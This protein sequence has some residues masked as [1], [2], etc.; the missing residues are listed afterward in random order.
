M[1]KRALDFFLFS[2]IYVSISV[3]LLSAVSFIVYDKLIN[4]NVIGF[5]YFSTLTLYAF[6]QVWGMDSINIKTKSIRHRWA[7]K[8]KWTLI[9]IAIIAGSCTVGF[10]FTLKPKSLLMLI[11]IGVVSIGYTAPLIFGKRLRDIPFIK[12]FLISVVVA[13]VVVVLPGIEEGISHIEIAQLFV[14][15]TLFLLGITIP[16]DIR[17]MSVD[18][19]ELK[20]IPIILG[21][22]KAKQFAI[23]AL[24]SSGALG[25]YLLPNGQLFLI[26]GLIASFAVWLANS[27][28]NEYYFLLAIEGMMVVQFVMAYVLA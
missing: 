10:V 25:W 6:H 11:P 12:V 3:A 2:K 13:G 15:Q 17:D 16:F 23:L 5:A 27:N 8:N 1:L 9:W 7:L 22:S 14:I 21:E 26:T 28:R 19:A 4:F 18:K 24:L 20:T